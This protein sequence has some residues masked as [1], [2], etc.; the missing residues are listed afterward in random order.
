MSDDFETVFDALVREHGLTSAPDVAIASALAG[1]MV[2]EGGDVIRRA[3]AIGRLRSLLPVKPEPKTLNLA[4]LTDIELEQLHAIYTRVEAIERG[5]PPP[6][7]PE[8][9]SKAEF[10]QQRTECK[11]L[12]AELEALREEN[13]RLCYE[14]WELGVRL[15]RARHAPPETLQAM[16]AHLLPPDPVEEPQPLPTNVRPLRPAGVPIEKA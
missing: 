9:V 5:D 6:P 15:A 12:R 13:N 7:E 8:F 2:E 14:R 11:E 16:N 1:V 4:L 10:E 3:E